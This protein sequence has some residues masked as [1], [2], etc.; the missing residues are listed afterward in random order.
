MKHNNARLLIL[1]TLLLFCFSL[2]GQKT[3]KIAPFKKVDY[4]AARYTLKSDT[5][6]LGKVQ[7]IITMARPK[8]I[9]AENIFCRYWLTIIKNGKITDQKMYDIEPVGGCSGLYKPIKQP[10]NNYF[11]IS[12]FGDYNGQTILIDT[13]GN[14]TSIPG[15]SFSISAD[16]NYL[17]T[18]HDSDISGI[19][20]FDLKNKKVVL[21]DERN[22]DEQYNEFYFQK[23]KYYVS[24]V[25][26]AGAKDQSVGTIDIKN[27]KLMV[28][29][30]PMSFLK[31][32]NKLI[33]FNNVQ[34][35]TNCNCGQH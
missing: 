7:I 14:I 34:S 25:A 2:L 8:I 19:T 12:K 32:T 20:I 27:K 5:S 17:F 15:G 21:N 31:I 26:E 18:I 16:N 9:A 33:T 13:A 30:N 35:L 29:K 10:L 22:D 1:N 3:K 28:N 4:P 24:F 6:Y 23:G 11:L